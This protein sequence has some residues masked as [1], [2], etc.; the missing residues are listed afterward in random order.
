MHNY[1]ARHLAR[2]LDF[3]E[4]SREVV[5]LA[6][7]IDLQVPLDELDKAFALAAAGALGSPSPR[8]RAARPLPPPDSAPPAA[9]VR[10]RVAALT[11]RVRGRA[12]ESSRR[13]LA[14]LA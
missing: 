1:V 14:G 6:S 8:S 3:A 4:R 2:V 5:P 9:S 12:R 7:L 10:G 11:T 13:I